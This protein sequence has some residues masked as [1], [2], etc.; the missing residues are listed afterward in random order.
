MRVHLQINLVFE[1]LFSTRLLK[2]LY[3]F[4]LISKACA[5]PLDPAQV[6]LPQT[7]ESGW[8]FGVPKL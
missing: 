8:L 4:W 7:Q 1:P 3:V 6:V 5:M 2:R